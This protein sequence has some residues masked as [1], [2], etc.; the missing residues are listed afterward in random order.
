GAARL[1]WAGLLALGRFH[2]LRGEGGR[3]AFR[4]ALEVVLIFGLGRPERPGLAD[5]GH[6]LAGPVA[7]GIDVT[8][9]LLGHL[10]L[11]LARTEDRRAVTGADEVFA[12][13]GPVELEEKLQQLPIGDPLRVEGDFGRLG[14]AGIVLLGGVIVLTAGPS[15]A[16]GDDSIAVTQQLLHDPEA[17]PR[18]DSGLGAVAHGLAFLSKVRSPYSR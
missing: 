14:V 4:I 12:K 9:R 2:A 6:D 5:L 8:D 16:G 7:R 11:L 1:S 13:V 15:H 3:A 18:E 10:A 17:S